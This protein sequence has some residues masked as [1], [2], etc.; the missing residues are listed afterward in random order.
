MKCA[1]SPP[2]HMFACLCYVPKIRRGLCRT[3][4][5]P[6][7]IVT[8]DYHAVLYGDGDRHMAGNGGKYTVRFENDTCATR[9]YPECQMKLNSAVSTGSATWQPYNFMH[10][11]HLGV[12]I[13]VCHAGNRVSMRTW[14]QSWGCSIYPS[15]SITCWE[16]TITVCIRRIG[17]AHGHHSE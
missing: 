7:A 16:L 15:D 8:H 5:C 13:I 1:P 14:A 10:G 6:L 17:V 4:D 9:G 2:G 12:L 11:L 3:D